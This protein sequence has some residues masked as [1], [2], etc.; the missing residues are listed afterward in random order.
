MNMNH[1]K[2]LIA[3]GCILLISGACRKDPANTPEPTDPDPEENYIYVISGRRAASGA[4][5]IYTAPSLD[6][7]SL[8]TRAQ[9]IEQSGER[10]YVTNGATLL[11]LKFG[12]GGA[13]SV[14]AYRANA[15]K[16][17]EK[18]TDFQTETMTVRGSI[19]D[20]VLMMKQAWQP[21]ETF[22]Q[23][24]R[25]DV[26][27]MQ[28]VGQGEFNSV[29]LGGAA[30][31]EK[32]FF[33][34][35]DKVGDYVF[36]PYW[37]IHSG[38]TFSTTYLDSA[39]VAVYEYPSMRLNKIIRDG[40]TGSVGNYFASG[41]D[42]D[43]KGDYY[44]I[45]TKAQ[46]RNN[47]TLDRTSETPAGILRINKGT[48]EFDKAFFF[49]IG[50]KIGENEIVGRKLY[51]G[52]GSFLLTIGVPIGE[53]FPGMK[54]PNP[55]ASTASIYAF[56]PKFA[57]VNVYNGSFKWVTG[58]PEPSAIQYCSEYSDNYSSLDGTGYMA[59]TYTEDGAVES[60]VY[61]FDAATASATRGLTTPIFITHISKLPVSE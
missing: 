61:K 6:E 57:I 5:V 37:S 12:G 60:S 55:Y 59:V 46:F 29:E 44:V 35:F 34:S 30:K 36:A 15:N 20:D 3:L 49:N 8:L 22:S 4:D 25:F 56:R 50:E 45:G 27:S 7:G 43:E 11:S 10:N 32:A 18:I 21:A 33:N 13:G 31:N 51:L 52:G 26:K 58:A 24:Y 41:A 23:W 53:P 1:N 19:G 39:Y 38:Q 17:L 14:T 54:V 42:L 48:T 40:R 2:L 28:I 9:G 16:M 47:T